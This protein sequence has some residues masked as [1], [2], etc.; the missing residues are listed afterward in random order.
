MPVRG[1]GPINS[2]VQVA[3]IPHR[4]NAWPRCA[5]WEDFANRIHSPG[6]PTGPPP[7]AGI[8]RTR[9]GAIGAPISAQTVHL[10][11]VDVA[12]RLALLFGIGTRALPSWDSKIRWNNL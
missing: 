3:A 9:Q 8:P 7:G 11:G 10:C 12:R 4:R 5:A 2:A 1:A 6:R